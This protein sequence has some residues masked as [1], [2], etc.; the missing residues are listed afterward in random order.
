M[1]LAA[2]AVLSLGMPYT[3]LDGLEQPVSYPLTSRLTKAYVK[4]VASELGLEEEWDL[5][6]CSKDRHTSKGF[7]QKHS[8]REKL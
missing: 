2:M 8:V 6:I 5:N 1:T 7:T 4:E 3:E